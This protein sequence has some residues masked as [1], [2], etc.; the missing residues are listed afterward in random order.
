MENGLSI[1]YELKDVLT[2]A[3]M[4]KIRMK[5]VIFPMFRFQIFNKQ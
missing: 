4:K 3:K 5:T 2:T 1:D